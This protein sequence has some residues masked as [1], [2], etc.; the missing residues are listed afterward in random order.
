MNNLSS[1]YI[2]ITYIDI[3]VYNISSIYLFVNSTY[4][5]VKKK[6]YIFII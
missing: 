3:S 1:I 6:I 4:L 5:F 2:C